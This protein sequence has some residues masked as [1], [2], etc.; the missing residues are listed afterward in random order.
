MMKVARSAL[1][2]WISRSAWS[3]VSP[4][5][6]V[7]R[8]LLVGLAALAAASSGPSSGGDWVK[9]GEFASPPAAGRILKIIHGWPNPAS[10]QQ[11][12]IERLKRQGF[13]GVTCNV[14]FDDYLESAARWQDFER[15][16]K[17]A[18]TAGWS[19]WL[20]DERGYPS[21]NAGGL[22]LKE[23][24][25]WEARGLLIADAESR[26]EPITIPAPP[27]T[28][29]FARAF[30]VRQ[31]AID[32][33]SGIDVSGSIRDGQLHYQPA[34]GHWRFLVVTEHRL[35]EGTHADGN[36]W[37]KMPYIDLLRPEPTARFLEL[38]HDRYAQRLGKEL[39]RLFEATFTDEP[40]LMSLF[41]RK[42]PYK[43]LPWSP[44]FATEFRKRRGYDLT[45]H[46]PELMTEAGDRGLRPRLDYWKTVGELVSENFFGQL[47]ARCH[48]M[49]LPSGGHLLGEELLSWHVPL[50]GD[51]LGCVR[52]MDA[53][54]IDCLTSIPAEVP[55]FIARMVASV[56]ELEQ[57]RLVMCETS[58]HSQHYRPP[59]DTRPIRRVSEA[60]IRGTAH[61][62]MLGGI[63]RITSYYSFDGLDDAALRRLNLHV[64][65]CSQ[66]LTGGY[67]DADL[68]V[69][70]PTESLWTRFVPSRFQT[71]DAP[72]ARGVE[73]L[74]RE[75]MESLFNARQEATVIDS[76]AIL[77][78][79]VEAGRLVHGP[80]AWRVVILPG[81]DTLP[82]AAWDRLDEFVARGGLVIVL[83]SR[84]RNTE[85]EF[86]SERI[87][88]MGSRWLGDSSGGP[89][90]RAN[91]AG[92]AGIELP[93]G[94]EGL[95]PTLLDRLVPPHVKTADPKGPLRT[96]HRRIEGRDV[97]LL[98]ND[99]GKAWSG[100]VEIE[101]DG[102]GTVWDPA[103]GAVTPFPDPR[104]IDVALDAY[105]AVILS[106]EH[107]RPRSRLPFASGALPR[108]DSHAL[109]VVQ[110][111]PRHGE[112][113]DARLSR[114][115]DAW[116]LDGRIGK[117]MVDTHLFAEFAYPKPID[118]STSDAL[119]VETTVP[120][121]QQADTTL[122]VILHEEGG[123]D[124][125]ATT[126]R[127]LSTPGRGRSVVTLDRFQVAPWIPDPD[128]VLDR[129]RISAIRIGWGGYFGKEGE[130]VRFRV[131]PPRRGTIVLPRER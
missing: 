97:F 89:T 87:A 84:P 42:M 35:F 10:D 24:P 73:R 14:S 48:A 6:K 4:V 78:S 55:W 91:P 54:S 109:P 44:S 25:E 61:R 79:R 36:I 85:S 64:G 125:I 52:R 122:L 7:C 23:H 63:N 58:D 102:P 106:H 104:R 43:V 123:G 26:G 77:E 68:A 67:Q 32:T 131:E 16:V 72:A 116:D 96:T 5:R 9:P 86:P 40:S 50:Y 56:A 20:Y 103:T 95:L 46:L 22:V 49:G 47:Q 83:G 126:D 62:L 124:F 2:C 130:H 31:G 53:P 111:V 117:G 57:R 29:Q 114:I 92:G 80:H 93:P 70:Y 21:G 41:L 60:E 18:H 37:Q 118:L 88:S 8:R 11:A 65:R 129:S 115:E 99:S 27:G 108:F 12:L 127:T 110:P 107:A 13:G 17:A 1:A 113:V 82:S 15:A 66:L 121:D 74:F 45:P 98:V 119:V 112:F 94:L 3:R 90:S 100:Q 128:N 51:F 76:R 59:G 34:P 28:L 19:M 101:A 30:P 105:G 33:A 81:V 71:E 38:T 39:P 120:T 75:V 69:V